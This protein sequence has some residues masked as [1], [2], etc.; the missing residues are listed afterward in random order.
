MT[1]SQTLG[2]AITLHGAG[3]LK[4][5]AKIYADLL[6]RGKD[7]HDA[8]YGLGTVL[9]Q[10]RR[11]DEA[12]PLLAQARRACPDVSEYA[13]NHAW[14]LARLG[15]VADAV[16]G[17]MRAAELAADDTPMIVEICSRLMT[18]DYLYEAVEIL[19]AASQRTP[20]SPE[21]WLALE[22]HEHKIVTIFVWVRTYFAIYKF[23]N[24]L[25]DKLVKIDSR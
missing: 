4:T 5:A 3:K 9:M 12:L 1:G 23:N 21:I 19:T 20:R 7:N 13:F 17:F 8:A 10:Q 24:T 2:A 16:Q 14:A 15:R 6:T 11:I 18:L 22:F 25:V